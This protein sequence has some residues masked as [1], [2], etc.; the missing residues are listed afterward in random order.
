M[1]E[2]RKK[3]N[4]I[5]WDT[6]REIA[7]ALP[8]VEESTSYR[9]PAIKVR[10]KLFVRLREECDV[11]VVRI[12]PTGRAMRMAGDPDAFFVTEHYAP[13]PYMLV[14]LS[15]VAKDDLAELLTDA[16]RLVRS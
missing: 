4:A 8:G 9:I 1:P 13:F 2:R 15:A 10:G 14:R 5:S 6:N 16:W 3:S 11:I 12:H 7:L